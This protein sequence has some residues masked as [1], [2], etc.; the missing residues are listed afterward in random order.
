MDP[1]DV[2]IYSDMEGTLLSSW[3]LGPMVVE[4][5]KEA[6]KKWSELG[7]SFSIATKRNLKNVLHFLTE[8]NIASPLVLANGAILYS[9]ENKEII[10]KELIP[11]SFLDEAIEYFKNNERVVLVISNEDEV[12]SV[13]HN[14][15]KSIPELD[16]PTKKITLDDLKYIN[17]IKVTFVV[18]ESDSE[19]VN[20]DI[21][22][23]NTINEVN[24]LP[25]S[26]RFIETVSVKAT[27]AT[28]IKKALQNN[29]NKRL[30]CIGDYLNDIEML[31]IADIPAC[32]K[33]SHEKVKKSAKII[34]VDN[35]VGAIADLINQL[36]T[37]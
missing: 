36:L 35:N 13:T 5:N 26:K 3:E 28:G 27:K 16:F 32:P 24:V 9:H 22:K 29:Y 17:I 34:T 23:F 11:N 12:F 8:F 2:I 15:S 14:S 18:F 25:S 33:N 21:K 30:V 1:K 19:Q 7:G 10:Y 4:E 31:N 37:S 6:L 20:N